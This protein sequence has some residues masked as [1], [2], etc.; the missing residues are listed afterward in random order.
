[1]PQSTN[2]T[3]I[4]TE[5]LGRPNLYPRTIQHPLTQHPQPLPTTGQHDHGTDHTMVHIPKKNTSQNM[6]QH[7]THATP[8]NN[9]ATKLLP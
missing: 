5:T 8:D 1:M 2:H 7:P 3:R 4:S 9:H 6:K